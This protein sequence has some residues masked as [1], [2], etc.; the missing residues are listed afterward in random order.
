MFS[1]IFDCKPEGITGITYFYIIF[2]D[3]VRRALRFLRRSFLLPGSGAGDSTWILFPFLQG[4]LGDAKPWLPQKSD[5]RSTSFVNTMCVFRLFSS[6][7]HSAVY[8][9]VET[10]TQQLRTS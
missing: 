4:H 7:K 3:Q 5:V 8:K 10:K 6:C 1:V 2:F 9:C